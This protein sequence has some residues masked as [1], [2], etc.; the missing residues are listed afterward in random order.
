[1]TAATTTLAPLRVRRRPSP[2]RAL[3]W[4]AMA[5]IVLVTLLPFYWILRT[6]LSSDASLT[7]HPTTLVP[8]GLTGNAFARVFGTESTKAALAQGG[9]GGSIHFWHYLLH[10]GI[11]STLITVCQALFSTM[12]PQ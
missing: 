9:A 11:V 3:A 4:T 1:M 7:A 2:G 12:A 5:G 10:S 6:A 8:A